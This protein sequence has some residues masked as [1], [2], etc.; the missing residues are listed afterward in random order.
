MGA[1][2]A[3]SSIAIRL[4]ALG[5][6]VGIVENVQ[7]PREHV[8]IC[9][10]D[11]TLEL[12]NYLAPHKHFVGANYWPRRITAVRWGTTETS[13]VQQPGL[14]VDRGELDQYMLRIASENGVSVYQPASLFEA[15]SM[16]GGGWRIAIAVG[17][18]RRE[19]KTF[20][21]VDAT[22][23]SS[24]L[25][26]VRLKDSPPLIAVHANWDLKRPLD[27]DG[28][29]E[30]GND[31]WLWYAQTNSRRASVSVFC[32]PQA[33]RE[34]NDGE[35]QASYLHLLRQFRLLAPN[36][37]ERQ[38][39]RPRACDA[40]SRHSAN[41]VSD[42][43][44]RVGDACL[45]VDPLSSQGVHLALLSGIQ[46][47]IIINTI[48]R[49]PE[50]IELAKRFFLNRIG[51]RVALYKHRTRT[52]Y[53][54]VSAVCSNEFWHER[55][56]AGKRAVSQPSPVIVAPEPAMPSVSVRVA[57]EVTFTKEPVINGNFVEE[58]TCVRHPDMEGAKAF[59]GGTSLTQ[60]LRILPKI[61][62]Y[63]EIPIFWRGIIPASQTDKVRRWLWEK[64]I[65][66]RA[67]LVQ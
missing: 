21:L 28:L 42:N 56:D 43:H 63:D 15:C 30:A 26:N 27:F 36:H 64:R 40:T 46:S 60:L 33:I 35:L 19:L 7:F 37:F 51:E 10:S 49:K 34:R 44:I 41:P 23:R 65:I 61:T 47:A 6:D 5:F 18:I 31:A 58:E 29:I 59:L 17:R 57:P 66:I 24:A 13:Y 39:S 16:D 67:D 38:S 32:S 1:G 62:T 48:L 22:G 11:R 14:H 20:F 25:S 55:A 54:R 4:A 8:G 12:L 50:N 45:S 3:G 52:E 2:P 53:A 9:L